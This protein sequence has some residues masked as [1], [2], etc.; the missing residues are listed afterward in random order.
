MAISVDGSGKS[1]G[2]DRTEG[3][4]PGE[5]LRGRRWENLGKDAGVWSWMKGAIDN[6]E[7]SREPFLSWR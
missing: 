6:G 1:Q 2:G 3:E 4:M 5:I 7:R